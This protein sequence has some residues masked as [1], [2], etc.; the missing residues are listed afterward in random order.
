MSCISWLTQ[1]Q[2]KSINVMRR[3][4]EKSK[5]LCC[6]SIKEKCEWSETE[7]ARL[8]Q[9]SQGWFSCLISLSKQRTWRVPLHVFYQC[10]SGWIRRRV[11]SGWSAVYILFEQAT[12]D[13]DGAT[14]NQ[15]IFFSSARGRTFR[16]AEEAQRHRQEDEQ[17]SFSM[18]L[19]RRIYTRYCFWQ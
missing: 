17:V 8:I 9:S 5:A 11:S 4:L 1:T 3:Q 10:I 2:I 16:G 7:Q 18:C 13:S 15:I 19:S 6:R 14:F 12:V